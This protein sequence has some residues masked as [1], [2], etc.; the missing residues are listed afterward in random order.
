MFILQAGTSVQEHLDSVI[1]SEQPYLFG[2]GAKRSCINSYFIVVDKH[3]LPCK[4]TCSI[5]AFDELFKAH[6]VFG[7]SYH[8]ALLNLY[9]F[10]QT[11]VYNIDVGKTKKIPE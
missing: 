10:I 6:F 11:P 5:E 3:A 8:Q 1:Q 4:A 9:T 7:I 2:M